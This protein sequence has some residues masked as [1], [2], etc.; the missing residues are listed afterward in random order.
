[1]RR[2]VVTLLVTI[3]GLLLSAS[4]ANAA[5]TIT[6]VLIASP[7]SDPDGIY[8]SGMGFGNQPPPASNSIPGYTGEDYGNALYL[9]DTTPNPN[10]WCA[11]QNNGGGGDVIGLQSGTDFCAPSN[12][13][14]CWNDTKFFVDLGSA[15][16]QYYYPNNI[17]RLQQGDHFTLTVE[18]A[19]CDGTVMYDQTVACGSTPPSPP[20]GP[21]PPPPPPGPT[22]FTAQATFGELFDGQLTSVPAAD[23]SGMPTADTATIAWGDGAI[24]P[25]TLT[26]NGTSVSIA[27]SHTYWLPGDQPV[28]ITVTDPSSHA[29]A[30]IVGTADIGSTYVGM[31]DSYSSGEGAHFAYSPGCSFWL[32]QDLFGDP[33]NTDTLAKSG[34]CHTGPKTNAVGNTCHRSITAYPNV[35][36]RQLAIAGMTLN[37]VACSG[38]I[39]QDAYSPAAN[40]HMDNKHKGESPQ[41][42]HIGP[43]DSLIT[44]T[45]GGNNVGFAPV[46]AD[47][48]PNNEFH[49]LQDDRRILNALGYNTTPGRPQDGLFD[50]SLSRRVQT[51]SGSNLTLDRADT[52]AWEGPG[53]NT[54]GCSDDSCQQLGHCDLHD[55]LVILYR[56]IRAE[57]PGARILVL[58]YPRFWPSGGT[59]GTCEHFSQLEQRWVNDRIALVDAVIHDAVDESGVAEYVNTYDAIAGHQLCQKSQSYSVNPLT[60]SAQ[61]CKGP[62]LNGISILGNVIGSSPELLHPNPCG[63]ANLAQLVVQAY[64]RSPKTGTFTLSPG[65]TST[66]SLS[67][68]P[69]Q[70][71]MNL[72]ASWLFGSPQLTLID[73]HGKRFTPVES[74]PTFTTWDLPDPAGGLW[75]LTEHNSAPTGSGT[76]SGT[77]NQTYASLAELPPAADVRMKNKSC[78]LFHCNYTLQATLPNGTDGRVKRFYWWS[79]TGNAQDSSGSKHDTITMSSN[80]GK[81]RVIVES[82]SP[83]GEDHYTVYSYG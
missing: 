22:S 47:C 24:T 2:T 32:Y 5:P 58:G 79:D 7:A 51:R 80:T 59:S 55:A 8:V 46:A 54:F 19:T 29:T 66:T 39:V 27:G 52:A 70:Q 63:H 75:K 20:P 57:A 68:N 34:G 81:L 78:F 28:T 45:F 83:G 31:G 18:G 43:A 41:L 64:G 60:G 12:I 77:L 44:L 72:T 13:A 69:H 40:V 30:M 62:Y 76:I 17:Y 6:S 23:F 48:V 82:V 38:D 53:C 26:A 16:S 56:A 42:T 3:V 71:R 35:V 15:Y 37:F 14:A 9:C 74:G 25:A 21:T 4:A 67:V 65:Q 33:S 10:T 36:E 73:P 1:V 11:G 49:C 61:N 50:S